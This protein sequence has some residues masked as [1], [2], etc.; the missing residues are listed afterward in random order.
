MQRTSYNDCATSHI[1]PATYS[2]SSHRN[3]QRVSEWLEKRPLTEE[4]WNTLDRILT[5]TWPWW[6][7]LYE[8]EDNCFQPIHERCLTADLTRCYILEGGECRELFNHKEPFL[9][10]PQVT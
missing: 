6:K 1:P 2:E 7:L 10:R 3:T 4:V 5:H 9:P 8:Q